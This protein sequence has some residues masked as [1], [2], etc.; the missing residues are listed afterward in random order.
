EDLAGPGRSCATKIFG[1]FSQ[2]S[3]APRVA[4]RKWP[5]R[6]LGAFMK[7]RKCAILFSRDIAL[8]SRAGVRRRTLGA[9]TVRPDGL[10][11]GRAGPR[12]L[13]GS[14][15]GGPAVRPTREARPKQL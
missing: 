1:G 2:V 11:L 13:C 8:A 15:R 7:P 4:P 14:A 10:G 9:A 5:H 3:A 12:S 6:A